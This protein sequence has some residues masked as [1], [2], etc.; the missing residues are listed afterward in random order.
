MLSIQTAVA[1]HAEGKILQEFLGLDLESCLI[2]CNGSLISQP[3]LCLQRKQ[4]FGS[5]PQ[6]SR[7]APLCLGC[8]RGP[9]VPAAVTSDPACLCHLVDRTSSCYLTSLQA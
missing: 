3:R 4:H 6:G 8:L 7:K 9:G 1:K 2:L 5:V